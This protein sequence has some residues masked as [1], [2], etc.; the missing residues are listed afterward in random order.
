[1]DGS[2]NDTSN[3]DTPDVIYGFSFINAGVGTLYNTGRSF[4]ISFVLSAVD[5]CDW[6]WSCIIVNGNDHEMT[7]LQ[8]LNCAVIAC[9]ACLDSSLNQEA[10]QPLICT[11]RIVLQKRRTRLER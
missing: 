4:E 9:E 7:R 2:N 3:D 10:P 11:L 8:T 5:R 1:M 6:E